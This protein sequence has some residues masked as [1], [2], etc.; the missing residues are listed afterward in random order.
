MLW[1]QHKL[2]KISIIDTLRDTYERQIALL[3]EQ[4]A[5]AR[6][7]AKRHCERADHAVDYLV[8]RVGLQAISAAGKRQDEASVQR[9][10]ER[11]SKASRIDPFDDCA[12]D[13]GDGMFKSRE[14][15]ALIDG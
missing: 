10:T 6:S 5:D 11:L 4:L 14:E 12:F 13:T 15:A 7:D 9:V 2:A 1:F 3:Q 8:N